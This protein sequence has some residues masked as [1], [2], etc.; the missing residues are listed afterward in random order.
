MMGGPDLEQD[1]VQPRAA[2][3][4]VDLARAVA[5][6]DPQVLLVELEQAQEVD[7]VD[8]IEAQVRRYAKLFF[9]EPNS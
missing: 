6:A 9:A 2:D 5:C 8:F 4:D 3:R 7:E 1:G